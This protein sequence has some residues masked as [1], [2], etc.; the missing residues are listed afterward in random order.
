MSSAPK[1]DLQIELDKVGWTSM[2]IEKCR[3]I[4]SLELPLP[5]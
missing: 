1:E 3:L 4:L 2:K 5:F